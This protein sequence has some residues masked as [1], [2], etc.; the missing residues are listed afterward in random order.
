MEQGTGKTWVAIARSVY[1]FLRGKIQAVLVICP[2]SLTDTWVEEIITHCPDKVNAII[3]VW[4]ASLN[5]AT[6]KQ[7]ESVLYNK[8]TKR[9][10]F[11]IMNIEGIR[12]PKANKLAHWFIRRFKVHCV[13][14]ESSKIKTISTKQSIA[15]HGIAD[16]SAAKIILTGTPVTKAPA[17]YY[18][19][20]RFLM[21]APL[22]FSNYYSFRARYCILE[23]KVVRIAK[24]YFDKKAKEFKK[25]RNIIVITGAQNTEELKT[26]LL[27]FSFFVKKKDCLDLPPKIPHERKCQLTK[28]GMR[29][30]KDIAKMI[31]AEI[32]EDRYITTEIALTKLLRLQ[33]VI[34]GFLPSDD[35]IH[36]TPIPGSNP[37]IDLLVETIEQF[38]GPT[39][40]WARFKAEHVAII[41]VLQAITAADRIGEITGRVKK[42]ERE[43]TRRAFQAGQIDY[44]V[45]T[46]SCAGYGYTLHAAEN[47][48]YYS[49]TFSYEHRIQSEDRAHRIGL[50]H[51]VNIID[52][53]CPVSLPRFIDID[54]KIK[55]TLKAN[56]DMAEL[57]TDVRDLIS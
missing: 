49:N 39:L 42:N 19:Q 54:M 14:D 55:Q 23:K 12:T 35:D 4:D 48:I 1:N 30:Y 28:E 56:C 41:R 10:T 16:Y 46:Q 53:W 2:K 27:P 43:D 7:L 33:Q 18:S 52:L 51:K 11:L 36:A 22:G 17:D 20:L 44:I 31:V 25:T 13:C 15:A 50:T 3:A 29:L 34:G 57:C 21:G 45:C 40:I 8:D 38:P 6:V 9:L 37:K 26:R 47:E 32:E 24:P 5:K